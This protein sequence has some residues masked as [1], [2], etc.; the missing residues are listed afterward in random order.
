MIKDALKE[1]NGNCTQAA[2]LLKIERSALVEK[3]KRYGFPMGKP[4]TKAEV[5][6]KEDDARRTVQ[7]NRED[8]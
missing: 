4:C 2:K 5:Y 3:R 8:S 1:A 7:D 6:Q